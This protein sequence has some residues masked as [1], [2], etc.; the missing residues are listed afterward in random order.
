MTDVAYI[1]GALNTVPDLPRARAWYEWAAVTL[2]YV[3]RYAARQVSPDSL[4]L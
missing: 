4:L 1:S 3:S 2:D